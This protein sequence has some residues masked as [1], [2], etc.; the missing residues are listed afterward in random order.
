LELVWALSADDNAAGGDVARYEIYRSDSR[1]GRYTRIGQV[2]AGASHFG[3]TTVGVGNEYFYYVRTLDLAANQADSIIVGPAAVSDVADTDAPEDASNF[4]AAPTHVGGASVSVYL[5]W[6]P[7]ANTDGDLVDQLLYVSTDNGA[8]YGNNLP[9]FDNGQPINLG[10]RTSRHQVT[11]LH[12]DQV[13]TFKLTAIDEVP[14]ESNGATVSA[15]PTGAPTETVSLSGS[16]NEDTVLSA[17]VFTIGGDLTVA[18]GVTLSLEPGTIFKF[19]SGRGMS[20]NGRLL[21]DDVVFTAFSDD[22]HGGDTNGDGPS[23]GTPGAW[24]RVSFGDSSNGSRLSNSV[25]AYAGGDNVANVYAYRTE[26][27]VI[28]GNEIRDGAYHGLR[29]E[30]C[31]P[32]VDGN[33]VTR[34]AQQG[35]YVHRRSSYSGYRVPRPEIRNNTVTASDNGLYL[36]YASPA[37]VDNNTLTDN[38]KHGIYTVDNHYIP[39]P[40]R[41]TITGNNIPLMVPASALPDDTNVVTPNTVPVIHVRSNDIRIDKRLRVWGK[42]TADE[43]KSYVIHGGDTTVPRYT[44]LTIAP[45]VVVKFASN[46]GIAVNGALVADGT[47]GEKV[48]FTS[49]HDDTY[50]G[51]TN[52]NGDDTIPGNGDWRGITFSDPLLLESVS[53]INHAR[54]RYGGGN[55]S[56]NIYLYR[57]D[58]TIEN[59]E[60]S[61]SSTHGIRVYEASPVITGN[62]IWGNRSAGVAIERSASNATVTFNR[63]ST[64]LSNGIGVSGGARATATNN[65]FLMNRGLG[66]ANNTANV[67]DASQ[68]W[69]GDTDASGPYHATTN[70]A[71][72]GA[73]VSDNVTFAPYRT[74][75]PTQYAYVNYGAGAGSTAGS[76]PA[77]VLANG[78]LSDEWDTGNQRADRTMAW[79]PDE[80][81]VDYAGL[82]I[83]RRYKVRISYFNGDPARVLQSIKDGNNNPLHGAMPMPASAPVQYEFSVPPAYYDTDGNLQLKFVHDNPNTS[84]RAAVTEVWLME[85]VLDLAPPRFERVAFNDFDGSGGPSPGDE[86]YFHFSEPMDTS[87][88]ADGTSDANTRLATDTGAVYGAVNQLRWSADE[89]AVIV[90]LT[91]GSSVNGS[92]LVTPVGL[93]DK[94]G[95]EVIGNQPLNVG[96]V[97]APVF[98]AVDW[99]DTDASGQLTV[100]DQYVFHFNEAMDA[101][102]VLDNSTDANAHLRPAGGKRYG[103]SNSISW[104]A[105]QRSVTVTVT[106]GHTI[107]GDERVIPGRFITDAA[108]NAVSGIQQLAGRDVA[109]PELTAVQF[110]DADG[111]HS[112]SIGDRYVFTFNEAMRMGA[113]SDNTTE[114]N[115]NLSPGG[116]RYGAVNRIYWGPNAKEVTVEITAG[117]TLAGNEVLRPSAQLT[118]LSDN[119]LANTLTLHTS[120]TVAPAIHAARGSVPSPVPLTS[121]YRVIVQFTSSVRTTAAEPVIGISAPSGVDP[122]VLPGGSWSSA[123][124]PN[125]TYTSPAITLTPQ[126]R[127]GSLAVAI[128]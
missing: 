75:V 47:V 110:D 68:S 86:F 101:S 127:G 3:D 106:G 93:Q 9:D 102:T 34:H 99:I 87:L 31:S 21:A 124:F 57:A 38:R 56:A 17:G 32:L 16:F 83:A 122:V 45:G 50:G 108:G 96:D 97:I 67:V 107:L 4:T 116:R 29:I 114:A 11:G 90:T 66:L 125:D 70:T 82:D 5:S 49:Y 13:Y 61:N 58:V 63:I 30:E 126:M 53:H 113:L 98:T 128:S 105:D 73:E 20:V 76:M 71:G 88:L 92:E 24:K 41:N 15:T 14:N 94:F 72:A 78:Q 120:D 111:D 7:S 39:P 22:A 25:V 42:G 18:S 115:D 59:S 95:N 118:D 103:N 84:I 112:V 62:S 37:E 35:I 123:V 52:G 89:T 81:V 80:V 8:A 121:D 51:D 6:T 48:I 54:I 44:T 36:Q 28:S 74:D 85:D 26:D 69:W 33:T 65:Q 2:A 1:Q 19:K 40:T 77:P 43:L 79:D 100:N 46:S 109:A 55:R 117:Y 10:R 12:V 60:I 27:L 23:T 91:E 64:N 119:A 104:S